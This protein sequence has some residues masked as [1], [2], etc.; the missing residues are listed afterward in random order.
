MKKDKIIYWVFTGL[1][2]AWM[3]VQGFMFT[4]QSDQVA[5]LF[6]SLGMPLSLIIPLGV[7]K[8]LAVVAILT[9]LSPMLKKLAYAG[10]AVDFVVALG[11]H[12]MAGD[13]N[14][15]GATAALALVVVSFIY[16][17]KI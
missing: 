15:P 16:S 1:L 13:G 2:S 10:L 7:A 12:L 5:E 9:R 11:A 14:W 17:R 6:T 4:F 8:I 3:L